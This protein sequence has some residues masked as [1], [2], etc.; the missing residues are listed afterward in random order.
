MLSAFIPKGSMVAPVQRALHGLPS[1][2]MQVPSYHMNP[3]VSS[4]P[5]RSF[6]SNTYHSTRSNRARP[7]FTAPNT[8]RL[9]AFPPQ[10]MNPNRRYNVN[11][12]KNNPNNSRNPNNSNNPNNS[13]NPNNSNNPNNSRNP[14]NQN[15]LTNSNIEGIIKAINN[16]TPTPNAKKY[17]N[18]LSEII[19]Y[20][21]T[22]NYNN[23]KNKIMNKLPSKTLRQILQAFSHSI[24]KNALLKYHTYKQNKAKKARKTAKTTAHA[25]RL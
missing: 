5:K 21:K 20:I 2:V 8:S 6:L 1:T 25:T 22:G 24:H 12:R 16:S 13:R 14:R 15:F 11:T 4:L 10:T 17:S 3:E 18:D 7:A 23:K 19:D 9:Q